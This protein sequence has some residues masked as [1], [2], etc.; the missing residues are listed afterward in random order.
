VLHS[1]YP[2]KSSENYRGYLLEGNAR[3][4]RKGGWM[5]MVTIHHDRDTQWVTVSEIS[6]TYAA[7]IEGALRYGRE[8]VDGKKLGL[9]I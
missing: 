3:G 5:G 7:A 1:V 8:M 9:D 2:S 4:A 6:S